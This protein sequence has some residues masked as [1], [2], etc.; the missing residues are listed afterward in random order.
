MNWEEFKKDWNEFIGAS[1]NTILP[2]WKRIEKMIESEVKVVESYNE[3]FSEEELE[4]WSYN[5]QIH[6]LLGKYPNSTDTA[7]IAYY[8][9][10][11]FGESGRFWIK[12]NLCL[13]KRKKD[14]EF[15]D[16]METKL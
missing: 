16:F 2:N 7:V 5:D 14:K 1:F 6:Y 9:S 13:E 12:Y 3:M 11:S 10:K 8:H 4:Q 15:F